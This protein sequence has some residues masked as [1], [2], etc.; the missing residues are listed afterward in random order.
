MVSPALLVFKIFGGRTP[1]PPSGL[2][3]M[4]FI[5]QYSTAQHKPLV[6]NE[7]FN[8]GSETRVIFLLI[9]D[10]WAIILLAKDLL[11]RFIPSSIIRW[12]YKLGSNKK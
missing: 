8:L 4:R 11:H 2:E 6:L 12:I 1:D 5:F 3:S 9:C 10:K 7:V